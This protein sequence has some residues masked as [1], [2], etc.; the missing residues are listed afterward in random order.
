MAS[1]HLVAETKLTLKGIQNILAGNNKLALTENIRDR[2]QKCQEYLEVKVA[3]S[4]H[5]IYGISTGFGALYDK[6][7]DPDDH[8]QLQ[9]NLVTSHASGV[10]PMIPSEIV[11]IMLLLKIQSLA[12]GYSAVQLST[13]ERL[14]DFFNHEISPV[15]YEMG[16]LGASGDLAPLRRRFSRPVAWRSRRLLERPE[17]KRSTSLKSQV[18]SPIITS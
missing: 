8:H 4:D 6:A 13:V 7:I 9:V 5:P 17:R 2:I 11:R 1:E 18:S 15:V 14:M 16:S 12:Y 10:G 3:N